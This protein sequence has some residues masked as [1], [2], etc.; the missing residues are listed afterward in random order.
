MT[1][2]EIV[3]F[4]EGL[5]RIAASGGGAKALAT[6]VAQSL[7]VGVLVEDVE[8]RHLAAAGDASLPPSARDLFDHADG[9]ESAPKMHRNSSLGR[10]LPIVAGSN[11]LGWLSVFP[12]KSVASGDLALTMRLSAAAIAVELARD[13][14][15]GRGRRRTFWE[16]LIAGAYPDA[17]AAR[18]DAIA[19]GITP[20]A[21]YVAIA[22]EPELSDEAHAP[23]QTADVRSIVAQAFH[24]GQTDLGMLDRGTALLILV[25]AAR[26]VD[27]DN[28]RTAAKLLPKT[29]A[30]RHAGL[31]ISGGVGTAEPL[32]SARLSAERADAALQIARRLYGGGQVGVYEELGAYPIL[33]EGASIERL[34]SF[35]QHVLAPLRAY[36]DKHQ[37]ELER[38]LRLYFETGQNV[39]TAATHLNVHR[40]TVFYRL[41]QIGEIA[42]CSLESPHDQ[43][44]LRLA[45]A[46]DALHA[47]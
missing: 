36:D 32:Q 7:P 34:T 41:R 21:S 18:D 24:A 27:A 13:A 35:T 16:R 9:A 25:P 14:D 39:K 17:S 45:I 5:A 29:V 37:T 19:R 43:L 10:T 44:T 26:E 33:L 6:Y 28:A 4:A 1:P 2:V 38:T 15:G 47:V 30:K 46:I 23:A 31:R 3:E 8:W 20:T 11:H 42:R 12:L 22:I 40:H